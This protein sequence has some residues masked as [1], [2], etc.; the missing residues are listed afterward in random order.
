MNSPDVPSRR[1]KSVA[2]KAG[3]GEFRLH[4]LRHT[5]ATI[6]LEA[7]VPIKVISERLGHSSV[8]TTMDIYSHVCSEFQRKAQK[9]FNQYLE[10]N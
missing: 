8:T 4:D 7:G 5:F 9:I 10:N 2:K 1:F 6:S 3:L